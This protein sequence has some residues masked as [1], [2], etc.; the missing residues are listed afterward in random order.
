MDAVP[1]LLNSNLVTRTHRVE[2]A[3]LCPMTQTTG[4]ESVQKHE[5]GI[6]VGSV[7]AEKTAEHST[8]RQV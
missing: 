4:F 2:Y 7:F 8:L 5:I 6:C 3:R 1:I